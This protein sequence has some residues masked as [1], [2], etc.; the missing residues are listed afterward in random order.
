MSVNDPPETIRLAPAIAAALEAYLREHP[1]TTADSLT[2]SL[3]D[4]YL[5]Q[6][7]YGSRVLCSPARTSATQSDKKP[8]TPLP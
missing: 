5:S 7:G 4:G 2:N 6:L 1:T 3:L 8:E